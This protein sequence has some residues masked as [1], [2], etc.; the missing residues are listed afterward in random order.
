MRPR[1]GLGVAAVVVA[2]L[3]TSL[4]SVKADPG[5]EPPSADEKRSEA[6]APPQKKT[7]SRTGEAPVTVEFLGLD[8]DKEYVRYSIHVNTDKPLEQVDLGFSYT[9]ADGKRQTETLIWQNI[10]KSKQQP[11]EKGKTYEDE[12]Y[13][14]PGATRVDCKLL[15]VVYKDM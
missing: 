13:L 9:G 5:K 4:R 7:P 8:T 15:R 2:A 14:G 11:I 12:R 6:K 10:V 1:T 3:L